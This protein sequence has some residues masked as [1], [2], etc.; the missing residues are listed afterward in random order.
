MNF[1][2]HSCPK[3]EWQTCGNICN[4]RRKC[5]FPE[6]TQQLHNSLTCV[7]LPNYCLSKNIVM[8]SDWFSYAHKILTARAQPIREVSI[9]SCEKK[10]TR[11]M[12]LVYERVLVFF[13]Q[14]PT[15][16]KRCSLLPS[17]VVGLH[18]NLYYPFLP[19]INKHTMWDHRLSCC[20]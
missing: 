17:F 18:N 13:E 2:K 1:K 12:F 20:S 11:Y 10:L 3:S 19:W 14:D 6:V 9:V 16:Y 15:L 4:Q 5:Y 7:L 8:P